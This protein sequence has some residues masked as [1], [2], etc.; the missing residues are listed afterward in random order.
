MAITEGKKRVSRRFQISGARWNVAH[1]SWEYTLKDSAG[2]M[3]VGGGA[4][5]W[6]LQSKIQFR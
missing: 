4:E 1:A 5:T 6:F 3:F 2:K